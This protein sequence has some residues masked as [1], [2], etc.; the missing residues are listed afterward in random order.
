LNPAPGGPRCIPLSLNTPR[1]PMEH[2]M[3]ERAAAPGGRGRWGRAPAFVT[4]SKGFSRPGGAV[5]DDLGGADTRRGRARSIAVFPSS[6]SPTDLCFKTA[7]RPAGC[8]PTSDVPEP[9][10]STRF[11]GTPVPPGSRG[12][13]T[14]P[15]APRPANTTISRIR[16]HP[17]IR[18]RRPR[19][20]PRRGASW[21][22][23]TWDAVLKPSIGGPHPEPAAGRGPARKK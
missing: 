10:R 11:E 15:R 6:S 9:S 19:P 22:G 3:V 7:R 4:K 13:A 1:T 8:S 18:C 16:A 14:A 12:P 17:L 20:G 5:G 21:S 2:H 23:V